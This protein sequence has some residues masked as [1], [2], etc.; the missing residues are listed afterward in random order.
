MIALHQA[1]FANAVS[2]MGTAITEVQIRTLKKYTKKIIL[3]LDPDSA[4]QKAVLRGLESARSS[5]DT[6]DEVRFDAHGLLRHENRLNADLRVATMPD[7]LDPDEVVEKDKNIWSQL[8]QDAKPVVEYVLDTLI[9]EQDINSPKNKS[10]IVARM[11]P[12]IEDLHDPIERDAYRQMV[13]RRLHVDERALLSVRRQEKPAIAMRREKQGLPDIEPKQKTSL[14]VNV[15]EPTEATILNILLH[16][17]VLLSKLD[18]KLQEASL[19]G[20]S[21]KDLEKTDHQLILDLLQRSLEQDVHD[22]LK[23]VEINLPAEIQTTLAKLIGQKPSDGMEDKL[24]DELIRSVITIRKDRI[25]K[26]LEQISYMMKD[27]EN[28]NPSRLSDM[29]SEMQKHSN[30]LKNLDEVRKKLTEYRQK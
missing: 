6:E 23:Y 16:H 28:T 13:A 24:L 3:A 18:R 1:G 4:G 7:G 9:Q 19:P 27:P 30:E 22:M 5:M 20:L 2:P 11:L 8:I 17:P 12:L 10:A 21:V 25:K 15:N 14:I 29:A 26:S